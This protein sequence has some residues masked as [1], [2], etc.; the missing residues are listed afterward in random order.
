MNKNIAALAPQEIWTKFA[1]LCA[2]PRPSGHEDA[3]REYLVAQGKA[4]GIESFA[5]EAGNVIM[6]NGRRHHI[7]S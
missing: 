7:R 4:F 1:E 3:I 6:R 5:D 2:I